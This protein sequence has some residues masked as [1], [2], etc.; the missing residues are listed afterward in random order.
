MD[1]QM[2]EGDDSDWEYEYHDT[3]TEVRTHFVRQVLCNANIFQSFYVTL[4][5]SST[6]DASRNTR[7]PYKKKA[8][9]PAPES[10][11]SALPPAI[12]S[13]F[14]GADDSIDPALQ[15][16]MSTD[17]PDPTNH[18]ANGDKGLESN[19]APE[20]RI[21]ILDFHTA[22]PFISYQNQIYSCQW[23][24]TLGTDVLLSA[25]ESTFEHPILRET[26]N[27]SVIAATG[28]KLSGRPV[29][30]T[31]RPGNNVED[32]GSQKQMPMPEAVS[33]AVPSV[34]TDQ[35]AKVTIPVGKTPTRARQNQANFLERLIAIKTA[36]GETDKLTVYTQKVNQ[37]SGWR[38]QHKALEDQRD[39]DDGLG[40][41]P[42]ATSRGR[43]RGRP[44]RKRKDAWKKLGPKTQKGGLFRDYR[45]QLWDTEGADI[46]G[47]PSATPE[48]WDQLG[49]AED[50]SGVH[51]TGEKQSL[52]V[53]LNYQPRQV[54]RGG[55]RVSFADEAA[56]SSLIPGFQPQR[57]GT[58][59]HPSVAPEILDGETRSLIVSL[60]YRP[61]QVG[62]NGD[63]VSFADDYGSGAISG[64]QFSTFGTTIGPLRASDSPETVNPSQQLPNVVAA[65]GV[66]PANGVAEHMA[67]NERGL[68][69][70]KD[71]DIEMQDA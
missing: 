61:R 64:V 41:I 66:P 70:A 57:I 50:G 37:G 55:K 10:P 20:G 28:I 51:D 9:G 13:T 42:P 63:K 1:I 24:S 26:P 34:A 4:D 31:S 65:D 25:P 12:I 6:V 18:I 45:P 17:G 21:Q 7:G 59:S 11:P 30:L 38:S 36:K 43:P 19:R 39:S 44:G 60:K 58:R 33:Q 14:D 22:N 56:S 54:G 27:L 8:A 68:V 49:G 5:I 47:R 15:D 35:P 69:T 40:G 32:A 2:I 23:T 48:S 16:H 62:S 52:I 71:D 3:E 46:R 29:Q 67:G 53:N